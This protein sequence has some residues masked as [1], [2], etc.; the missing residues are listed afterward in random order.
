VTVGW[1]ARGLPVSEP[2]AWPAPKAREERFVGTA[3][4]FGLLGPFHTWKPSNHWAGRVDA[5]SCPR[6]RGLT[7][8]GT[9]GYCAGCSAVRQSAGCIGGPH[10]RGRRAQWDDA[11]C[12][13][14]KGCSCGTRGA[15]VGPGS[16]GSSPS[17]SVAPLLP[18]QP[19]NA[20]LRNGDRRSPR[21]WTSCARSMRTG[22]RARCGLASGRTPR[23]SV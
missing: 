6:A 3:L 7:P 16:P 23:S 17:P 12:T 22:S 1:A 8:L 21:T 15:G 19:P 14:A 2:S 9:E 11:T 20:S 10:A 4:A 13:T 5:L 18:A